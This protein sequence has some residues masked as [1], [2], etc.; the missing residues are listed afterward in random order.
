M[1]NLTLGE[2]FTVPLQQRHANFVRLQ[3]RWSNSLAS[4]ASFASQANK[5]LDIATTL[6]GASRSTTL[7][8]INAETLTA[9]DPE[10]GDEFAVAD[11]DHSVAIESEQAALA[12]VLEG[13]MGVLELGD[14]DDDDSTD[15]AREANAIIHWDLPEVRQYLMSG[16]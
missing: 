16:M 3:S 7:L 2:L 6:S 13:Q 10:G 8:S 4:P 9:P 12:D 1:C 15:Y 5:A 14:E 11:P